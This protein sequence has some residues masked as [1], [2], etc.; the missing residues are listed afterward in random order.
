MGIPKY[1]FIVSKQM[2]W[3]LENI[4]TVY[5]Y[6]PELLNGRTQQVKGDFKIKKNQFICSRNTDDHL[7]G[8]NR[9]GHWIH[10]A[11]LI[12]FFLIHKLFH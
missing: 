12:F 5:F 8:R 4:M 7:V 10:D 3:G 9:P 2:V 1:S 6:M 11:G